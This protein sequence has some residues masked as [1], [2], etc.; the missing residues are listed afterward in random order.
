MGDQGDSTAA[1]ELA[2]EAEVGTEGAAGA[3]ATGEGAIP[4]PTGEGAMQAPIGEG[5]MQAPMDLVQLVQQMEQKFLLQEER[6][7]QLERE[8]QQQRQD[9]AQQLLERE[10]QES[11]RERQELLERERQEL[12]ER[13]RQEQVD[14]AVQR[15][16][17]QRGHQMARQT[18]E[19]E[20]GEHL[21][22]KLWDSLKPETEGNGPYETE[23]EENFRTG[24]LKNFKLG[25]KSE[26][27]KSDDKD[28][29]AFQKFLGT[30]FKELVKH[31][32]CW[33]ERGGPGGM[34]KIA[35]GPVRER[36]MGGLKPALS[37]SLTQRIDSVH[38]DV[39]R[40]GGEVKSRDMVIR[41]IDIILKDRQDVF[42]DGLKEVRKKLKDCK[43]G[44]AERPS[45]LAKRMIDLAEMTQLS[46]VPSLR[47][48]IQER[49]DLVF[50]A[51]D[52]TFMKHVEIWQGDHVTDNRPPKTMFCTE[53]VEGKILKK[54]CP[55]LCK[56]GHCNLQWYDHQYVNGGAFLFEKAIASHGKRPINKR[57][58]N[59]D[60][61]QG[62]V[63][64][65]NMTTSDSTGVQSSARTFLWKK[66]GDVKQ[67]GDKP[68]NLP[69]N[70]ATILQAQLKVW[71]GKL[72]RICLKDNHK[73]VDC[74]QRVK[75][76]GEAVKGTWGEFGKIMEDWHAEGNNAERLKQAYLQA[77]SGAQA[78]SS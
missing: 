60:K 2:A 73:S 13:E 40:A 61:S 54:G 50:D 70:D 19:P 24:K 30:F 25:G 35:W 4:A 28:V 62:R 41:T 71:Q 3:P 32:S 22:E 29:W 18:F 21:V 34:N 72:C 46:A 31:P 37:T 67:P 69:G 48:V 26:W 17:A 15:A 58:N 52:E 7:Q 12:L 77:G 75:R 42:R 59:G 6:T 63:S 14:Q 10:R 76:G 33:V 8:L 20:R 68:K 45:V 65:N 78:S 1:T 74:A 56:D 9:Q 57:G 53:D 27:K 36:L 64:F 66:Y 47:I 39:E 49:E 5:A 23:A 55:H 11:E 51:F 38:V 16:L 43:Q 44:P